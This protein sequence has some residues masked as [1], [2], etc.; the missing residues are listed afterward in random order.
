MLNPRSPGI[1]LH[2]IC[3]RP[4]CRRAFRPA[5]HPIVGVVHL[6]LSALLLLLVVRRW[7]GRPRKGDTP[8]LP[9]WMNAIDSMT[10]GRAFV[11]ALLLSAV[12]P[13]NLI[14][15]VSAGLTIGA[16]ALATWQSVVA[17]GQF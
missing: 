11:L 4:R 3:L 16:G 2:L 13:K 7:R 10:T 15:A 5:T 14:M 9:S 17:I 6:I 8:K 12:N 1:L